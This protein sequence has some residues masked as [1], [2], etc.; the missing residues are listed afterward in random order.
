MTL[1]YVYG[2]IA[3][4]EP[5]WLSGKATRGLLGR[6]NQGTF[7]EPL[8]QYDWMPLF[9]A[10]SG[11]IFDLCI[12]F[13]MLIKKIR[14][15]AFIAALFFHINNYVVFPIGV[16][17]PLSIALTLMYFDP[18]FPK[19]ISPSFNQAR[20]RRTV[21]CSIRKKDSKPKSLFTSSGTSNLFF[22]IHHHSPPFTISTLAL[23][24][25]YVMA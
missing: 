18:D 17:P 12:P 15:P 21:L 2:A 16:F 24:R 7:L 3:K 19:K 22:L 8:M 9:Y 5:D 1:V 23:P 20:V 14:I 11:M 6:A 10:W 13:A 4:M 25:Q